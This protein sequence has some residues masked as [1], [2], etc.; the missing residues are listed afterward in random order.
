MKIT[1][2]LNDIDGASKLFLR[3]F[4]VKTDNFL[5]FGAKIDIHQ[6]TKIRY[7][8]YHIYLMAN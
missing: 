3:D 1:N 6:H 5:E 8:S 2:I 7:A 4:S